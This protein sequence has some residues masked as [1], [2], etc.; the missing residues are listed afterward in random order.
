MVG[1]F[2]GPLD[3]CALRRKDD[4]LALLAAEALAERAQKYAQAV[5]LC[6]ELLADELDFAI[7]HG[8][9]SERF[10]ALIEQIDHADLEAARI[11]M[12][13]T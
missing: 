10:R 13:S 1:D 6:G 4:R 2:D 7:A 12:E 8:R 9:K 11:A 5:S 3:L